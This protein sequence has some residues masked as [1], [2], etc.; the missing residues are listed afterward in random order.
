[1]HITHLYYS[2]YW[3]RNAFLAYDNIVIRILIFQSQNR[4]SLFLL[5][6]SL[7]NLYDNAIRL[8]AMHQVIVTAILIMADYDKICHDNDSN[9][10]NLMHAH[11]HFNRNKR[12]RIICVSIRISQTHHYHV[13]PQA[14][15]RILTVLSA[16]DLSEKWFNSFVS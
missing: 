15:F 3:Y 1:M 9:D 5:L 8:Y 16:K 14:A 7:Q 4:D 12:Y 2:I 10:K 6:V 13:L 11:L